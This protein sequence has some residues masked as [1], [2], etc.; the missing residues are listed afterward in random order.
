MSGLSAPDDQSSF[1][2]KRSAMEMG[3]YI[4]PVLG[5][6]TSDQTCAPRTLKGE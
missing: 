5:L 6:S 3:N 4:Q 2:L 1:F